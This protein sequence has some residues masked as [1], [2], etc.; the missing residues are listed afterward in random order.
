M[1]T[2]KSFS[3]IKIG[4]EKNFGLV[5]GI[6]FFLLS[7]YLYYYHNSINY[8]F[9][10]LGII[11]IIISLVYPKVLKIP[12]LLWFKF[13]LLIGKVMIPIFLTFTYFIVFTFMGLLIKIFKRN[14]IDK[15]IEKSKKTY[16][17]VRKTD[18]GSFKDQF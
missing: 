14:Y 18:I 16:W 17:I 15:H 12:N 10:T 2:S 5:F 6:F 11:F 3:E 4:S 13:G 9:I 8:F 7:F 1:E